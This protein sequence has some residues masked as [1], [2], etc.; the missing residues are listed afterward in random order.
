MS[1]DEIYTLEN[2]ESYSPTVQRIDTTLTAIAAIHILVGI[3][4]FIIAYIIFSVNIYPG[5][6]VISI[7]LFIEG[8]TLIIMTPLYFILAWAIWKRAPWAW[9]VA[10]IVNSIFLLLNLVSGVILPALLNIVLLFALYS[11]DVRQ[12]LA[13]MDT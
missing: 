9:K 5:P 6:I 13:F 3:I 1:E 10:L 11:P 12:A 4:S 2:L 8:V 7:I